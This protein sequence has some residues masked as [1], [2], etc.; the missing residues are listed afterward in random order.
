M[1]SFAGSA[2]RSKPN[3]YV[4]SPRLFEIWK[5]QNAF[6]RLLPAA[7]VSV[8]AESL[9]GNPWQMPPVRDPQGDEIRTIDSKLAGDAVDL[10]FL[11]RRDR[12]VSCGHH[13]QAP[14]QSK[15][16][17]VRR[18]RGKIPGDEKIRRPAKEEVA[19]FC[20]LHHD[21]RL[22]VRH[23]PVFLH[24][25]FH[26]SRFLRR[27]VLIDMR[28]AAKQVGKRTEELRPGGFEVIQRLKRLAKR[29]ELLLLG[30]VYAEPR[31]DRLQ[32]HAPE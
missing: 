11:G 30:S 6:W 5:R 21:H 10:A 28:D 7:S 15:L 20:E 3:S 13:E 31:T 18:E 1:V 4:M 19:G 17:L 12:R 29:R 32:G 25:R 2:Y 23:V 26:R 22:I 14:H 9:A 8:T 24:Q 16:L 27:Y